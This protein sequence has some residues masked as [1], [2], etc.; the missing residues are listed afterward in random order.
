[1]GEFFYPYLYP[2]GTKPAGIHTHGSNC[3]PYLQGRARVKIK[4]QEAVAGN[5]RE[6]RGG[7]DKV[8]RDFF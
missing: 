4:E 8:G 7:G 5:I 6:T 2:P 3:H 1:M